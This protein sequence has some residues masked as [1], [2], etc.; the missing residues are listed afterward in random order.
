[1][2]L[3]PPTTHSWYF[4]DTF[5]AC[6]WVTS[7]SCWIYYA[8]LHTGTVPFNILVLRLWA[9][10]IHNQ[11]FSSMPLDINS[12]LLHILSWF[13]TLWCTFLYLFLHAWCRRQWGALLLAQEKQRAGHLKPL[14][15]YFH[16]I[17]YKMSVPLATEYIQATKTGTH[18]YWCWTK[19]V[20]CCKHVFCS[21]HF[22]PKSQYQLLQ[23]HLHREHDVLL[24]YPR[25]AI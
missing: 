23:Q 11:Y 13:D 16:T 22:C 18:V 20:A 12:V 2:L 21:I 3:I 1:M 6:H 9:Y 7:A 8:G 5:P 24:L 19:Q 4:R 14:S 25:C 17:K 15:P 10:Q